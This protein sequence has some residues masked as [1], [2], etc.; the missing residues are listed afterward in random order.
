MNKIW[1]VQVWDGTKEIGATCFQFEETAKAFMWR[2][3]RRQ[4]L[5]IP[6]VMVREHPVFTELPENV[7]E[8]KPNAS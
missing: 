3:A 2:S 4:D 8:A 7:R 5:Q 1:I 6:L